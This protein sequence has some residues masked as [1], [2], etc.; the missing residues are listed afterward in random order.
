MARLRRLGQGR[1][2]IGEQRLR[3]RV[4]F[5]FPGRILNGRRRFA[6]PIRLNVI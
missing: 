6:R 3:V 5:A 1:I 4:H 2:E